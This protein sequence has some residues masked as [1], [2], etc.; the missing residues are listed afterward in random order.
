M[1]N[2]KNFCQSLS[3]KALQS[4]GVGVATTAMALGAGVSA[5]SAS[6]VTIGGVELSDD[7]FATSVRTV[8][9][10]ATSGGTVTS[11]LIDQGENA[12]NTYAYATSSNALVR[13]GFNNPILNGSGF[14]LALFDL[15]S[16]EAIFKVIIN[17]IT[18]SYQ[19]VF[20]NEY[21]NDVNRFP[22]NVAKVNLDD[23]GIASGQSINSLVIDFNTAASPSLALVGTISRSVPE[24]S[25]MFGLLATVGFLA[26]QRKLKL[27]KKA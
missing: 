26:C 22:I 20:T 27:V 8:G 2:L 25:A 14:D 15:D 23:F 11:V 6:A 5:E 21:T 4:I 12:I 10:F 9:S 7:G 3:K 19:S 17:G 13:M 18:N 24:P 1:S 16:S